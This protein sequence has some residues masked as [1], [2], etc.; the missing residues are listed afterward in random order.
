MKVA[1]AAGTATLR[2]NH[3]DAPTTGRVSIALWL[4]TADK[5][6]APALRLGIEANVDGGDYFRYAT[7]GVGAPTARLTEQWA[8]YIFQVDDL[9]TENIHDARIRLDLTSPGEIWI[10]DVQ[11]FDLAFAE[12]E[13]V[14]LTKIITL[15]SYK[16][17]AGQVADCARILDGYWPQFLVANVPLVQ[18]PAAVAQRQK[19]DAVAPHE[20]QK[21]ARQA[22]PMEGLSAEMAA[23][24]NRHRRQPGSSARRPR[25]LPSAQQMKVQMIDRLSGQRAAV[26][27]DP[28]AL[29]QFQFFG[30]PPNH[31]AQV[32]Q[33]RSILFGRGGE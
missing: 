28:I 13:R 11:L 5:A 27:D 6:K 15:A 8:Q 24:L 21:E 14:E 2:S 10:D 17:Q 18:N 12:N 16:L 4:R 30:Q 29:P 31:E 32:S 33:Q 23:V 19:A 20:A 7:L 22:R 9:P 26:D 25:H 3:F 1:C